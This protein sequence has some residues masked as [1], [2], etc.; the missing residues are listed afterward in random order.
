MFLGV[1]YFSEQADF[2]HYNLE[3]ILLT[4]SWLVP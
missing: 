1:T 3:Y 2:L 4:L